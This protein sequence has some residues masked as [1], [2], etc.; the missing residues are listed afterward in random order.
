MDTLSD[1]GLLGSCQLKPDFITFLP[2]L[3]L[4]PGSLKL[5]HLHGQGAQFSTVSKERG[6]STYSVI[7][8]EEKWIKQCHKKLYS[9]P[10]VK[11]EER[12]LMVGSRCD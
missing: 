8:L 11:S 10:S 2:F 9:V 1:L 3:V 12:G 6:N 7:S 5:K 4:R